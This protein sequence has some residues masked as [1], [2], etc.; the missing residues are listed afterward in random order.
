V[1]IR[2]LANSRPWEGMWLTLGA[3]VVLTYYWY[4]VWSFA[5]GRETLRALSVCVAV[6][7]AAG[8]MM[9]YCWRVRA[10]RSNTLYAQPATYTFAP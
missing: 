10:I 5:T 8:M 4:P 1:G 7:V 9:F 2:I 6:F 3:G